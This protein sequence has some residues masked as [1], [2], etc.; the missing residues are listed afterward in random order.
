[1]FVGHMAVALGAKAAAPRIPL[2]TL[3]A[4]SFGL[5]LIWPLFVLAGLEH[6]RIDP[7]NT[8]FTPLAF[9]SYPWSHS[10]VMAIVWGAALAVVTSRRLPAPAKLIVAGTVISHWI[11]DFVS[12]R[13]DMPIV[14]GGE[15]F[16]LGLWN[17]VGLTFLVEGVMYSVAILWYRHA[18]PER[19]AVGRWSFVGL[20][21]LTGAAWISSPFSPPPPS[22]TAVAVVALATWLFVPWAAWIERHRVLR[23][24]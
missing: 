19:D 6:V 24:S 12:H 8:E 4:A 11:L 15:R 21:V 1:M 5:D 17:N 16:G 18:F 3:V 13:P 7:G 9:D 2:A 10:L 23:H 22:V 14:P 20:V